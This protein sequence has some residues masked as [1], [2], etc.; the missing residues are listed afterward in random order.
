[1]TQEDAED[2]NEETDV[3]CGDAAPYPVRGAHG[4]GRERRDLHALGGATPGSFGRVRGG[5][6]CW[7]LDELRVRRGGREVAKSKGKG[8]KRKGKG[9]GRG[10]DTGKGF[11][12]YGTYA[13]HLK[14]LQDARTSR[15]FGFWRKG[16]HRPLRTSI[17]DLNEDGPRASPA[18]RGSGPLA[19]MFFVSEPS[20]EHS[21]DGQHMWSTTAEPSQ[22]FSTAA[23][24]RK[25]SRGALPRGALP[26]ERAHRP[27]PGESW[28]SRHG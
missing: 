9:K 2:W 26:G 14:A 28:I 22:V 5:G 3:S 21:Q 11:A 13:D 15:G 19:N 8:K 4:D 16:D 24:C 17:Q 1:M 10:K 7:G 20:F 6:V 12:V 23:R 18:P 25:S 27:A